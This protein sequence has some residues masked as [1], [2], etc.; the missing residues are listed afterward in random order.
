MEDDATLPYPS[1]E[2]SLADDDES[3]QDNYTV[4][5]EVEVEMKSEENKAKGG[6]QVSIFF[7]SGNIINF[8]VYLV[9]Y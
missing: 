1:S 9:Y 3:I 2:N 5:V 8:N 7:S 4:E 6:N